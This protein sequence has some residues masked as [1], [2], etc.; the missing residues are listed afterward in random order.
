MA[1]PDVM[2]DAVAKRRSPEAVLTWS[3][4][5]KP[6]LSKRLQLF[7]SSATRRF[8]GHRITAYSRSTR[9]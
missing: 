6:L 7:Y 4:D 1:R 2:D 9:R 8:G 3:E 5:T